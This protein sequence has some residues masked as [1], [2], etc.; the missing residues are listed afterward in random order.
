VCVC[1]C[2]CVNVVANCFVDW[3]LTS[4]N[5]VVVTAMAAVSR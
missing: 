4:G 5:L 2:V 3:L 1:V